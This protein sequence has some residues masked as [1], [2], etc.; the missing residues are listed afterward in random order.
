[1]PGIRP[2]ILYVTMVLERATF[3]AGCFWGVQDAFNEV[4]GVKS[5]VAGYAG[6]RTRNPTYEEV[7][8]DETGHTQAVCVEY[9]PEEVSYLELLNISWSIHDPTSKNCQGSYFGTRYRCAIF[10]HNEQQKNAA[11]KTLTEEQKKYKQKITTS[12]VPAGIFYPADE[13]HQNYLQKNKG[14]PYSV[15]PLRR[16]K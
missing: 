2:A 15:S 11:E 9:D 7:G 10:C 6:G 5:T 4:K 13:R 3:A 16:R 12:I 1:M 14:T 8:E